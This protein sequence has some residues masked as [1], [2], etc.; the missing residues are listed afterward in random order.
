MSTPE[1]TESV[2]QDSATETEEVT[3]EHLEQLA[4]AADQ[5]ELD[6]PERKPEAEPE[7]QPPPEQEGETLET[8][9]SVGAEDAGSLTGE[10]ETTKPT[11]AEKDNSRL[12]KSWN[13]LNE[14]KDSFDADKAAFEQER[15]EFERSKAQQT[16]DYK[17][18]EGY[19]SQDYER[20]A[21]NWEEE[22][23]YDKADWAKKQATTVNTEGQQR[24]QAADASVFQEKWSAN[25][26]KVAEANPDLNTRTSDLHQ[27]VMKLIED[28]PFLA[29]YPDGI[30]DAVE[31]AKMQSQQSEVKSLKENLE[32]SQLEVEEYK[33]KLSIGGSPPAGRPG[34]TSFNAM[35]EADQMKR[36]ERL[37]AEYDSQ[38]QPM[39]GG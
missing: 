32:K 12:D 17:D 26:E 30:L 27:R 5:G 1:S 18:G 19:T 13:K 23:E 34:D 28:K 4:N 22:G 38:G 10:P 20:A 2:A 33:S 9:S 35:D 11:K 29:S 7:E 37:A 15:T 36:L 31:V 6:K 24:A 39:I 21:R 3:L 14:K 25:F 8:E 16:D